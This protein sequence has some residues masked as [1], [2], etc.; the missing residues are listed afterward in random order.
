LQQGCTYLKSFKIRLHWNW[1]CQKAEPIAS[2]LLSASGPVCFES[3]LVYKPAN[4]PYISL[5]II[6][7]TVVI[8]VPA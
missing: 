1:S 4:I 3:W 8:V 6:V 5:S 7:T 2:S